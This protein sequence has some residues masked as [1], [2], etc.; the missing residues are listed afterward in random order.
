MPVGLS[1]TYERT[2]KTSLTKNNYH[3]RS[4]EYYKIKAGKKHTD[5]ID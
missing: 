5:Q 3:T 2:F 4:T 1:S